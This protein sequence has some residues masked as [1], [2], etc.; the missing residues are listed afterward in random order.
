MSTPGRSDDGSFAREVGTQTGKAV[1]LIVVAVL[2]AVLLLH[3]ASG[4]STVTSKPKTTA[5]PALTAPSTTSTTVALIPPAS[6][7]LLVLNGTQK[8]VLAGQFTTKLKEMGYQTQ[9]PD[10]TTSV[11]DSSTVY[12]VTP[13]Y[14][15]EAQ[16]LAQQLGLEPTAVVTNLPSDAPVASSE[17]TIANIILVVSTDLANKA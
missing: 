5:A 2:V 14:A 3:H 12:A 8:G 11:V 7:K 16:F 6:I 10:N 9:T 1:V 13:Q 17:K 4:T 15:P